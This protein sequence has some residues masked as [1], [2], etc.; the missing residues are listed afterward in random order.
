[1]YRENYISKTK[2]V[3]HYSGGIVEK[4]LSVVAKWCANR[5]LRR[6][7]ALSRCQE[8]TPNCRQAKRV[9]FLQA[10]DHDDTA[11]AHRLEI[12]QMLS[13]CY[14]AYVV[15]VGWAR[16]SR[17]TVYTSCVSPERRS[18][19]QRPWGSDSQTAAY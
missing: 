3:G 19:F 15:V 13:A 9:S 2:A 10:D 11:H 14:R 8:Y 12:N 18:T 4:F 17:L 6:L 16:L 5:D 7:R 1:V